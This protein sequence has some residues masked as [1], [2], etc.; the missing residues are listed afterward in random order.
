M[1]HGLA[2]L[3]TTFQLSVKVEISKMG[4]Y[5]NS[6]SFLKSVRRKENQYILISSSQ[7]A[8]KEND[9]K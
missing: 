2:K 7:Y 8:L 6:E 4:K 5:G 1:K 3:M 9:T